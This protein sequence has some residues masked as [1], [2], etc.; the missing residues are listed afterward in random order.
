MPWTPRR[1]Q[2]NL[3]GEIWIEKNHALSIFG[4]FQKEELQLY[5]LKTQ[6]PQVFLTMQFTIFCL[7]PKWSSYEDWITLTSLQMVNDA[8]NNKLLLFW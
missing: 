3:T 5:G 6:L 2:S 7:C 8:L 4:V 1:S